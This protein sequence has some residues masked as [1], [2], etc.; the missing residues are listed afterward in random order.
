M[1]KVILSTEESRR[2]RYIEDLRSK[3]NNNYLTDPSDKQ[4]KFLLDQFFRA[5]ES[6]KKD[7]PRYALDKMELLN[8]SFALPYTIS[9]IIADYVGLP[10]TTLPVEVEESVMAYSWAGYSVFSTYVRDGEVEIETVDPA[11]YVQYDDYEAIYRY[12]REH[13]K[14]YILEMI[15]KMENG[16]CMRYSNLYEQSDNLGVEEYG[17]MGTP[18]PLSTIPSLM[19]IPEVEDL[20]IDMIPLTKIHNTRLSRSPYGTSDIDKVMS[21]ITSIEVAAVNIQDQFL[22]HLQAKLAVP[23]SSLARDEKTGM[24]DVRRLEVIG[25]DIGEQLPQYILN[26]NPMIQHSFTHIEMM[27]KQLCGILKLPAEFFP[28]TIKAGAESSETK[29]IRMGNFMKRVQKIRRRYTMALEEIN[30]IVEKYNPSSAEN[31]ET[32]TVVWAE[33]FPK[34]K[35][36][37]ALEL[38]VGVTSGFIS[39]KT[40][41]MRYLEINEAKADEEMQRIKEEDNIY[42]VVKPIQTVQQDNEKQEDVI[43]K[44]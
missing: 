17:I 43:P 35:H 40:A 21:L 24:V 25:V 44:Q 42:Q 4:T 6:K 26:Q 20:N 33:I 11:E 12:Y 15:Y 31:V 34:D 23:I 2:I 10:V 29:E 18:V 36:K 41:I 14:R 13:G 3:L 1:S 8:I 5:T 22:K 7:V 30:R 37:E 28:V 32:F 16:S 9:S 27:L 38:Q 19:G 39:R